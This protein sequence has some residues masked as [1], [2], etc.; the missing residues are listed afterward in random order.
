M[1][2]FSSRLRN[3][4]QTATPKAL[5]D[6]ILSFIQEQANKRRFA[7]RAKKFVLSAACSLVLCLSF[8]FVYLSQKEAAKS[9]QSLDED[10]Q[11]YLEI[12]GFSPNNSLYS[13]SNEDFSN[14]SLVN[15][16]EI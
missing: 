12:I 16:L 4:C 2:N 5:D 10:S 6:D 9:S 14:E 13:F 11:I 7:Y 1:D 8:A 15:I 3:A